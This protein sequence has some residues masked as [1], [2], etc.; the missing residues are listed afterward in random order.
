VGAARGMEYPW[1]P[2]RRYVARNS[3]TV[4]FRR[5]IHIRVD[6]PLISFTFDDFPRSALLAGGAILNRFGLAGTYYTA[7]GLLGGDSPS[8]A[9][10]TLD[11]LKLALD[12]GH[13]LGCHTFSHF[14]A[15]HTKSQAFEDS[16]IQNRRALSSLIP[17]AEFKSFSYPISSPRPTNKRAIAKL[18]ECCRGGGQKINA[19]TADL[20]QLSGYFLEKAGGCIP[21]IKSLIDTNKRERGWL[22]FATH[23]VA[24]D[25][26]PYGCTP[27]FFEDVVRYAADSGA[28]I[29]PVVRALEEIR[30]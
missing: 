21:P 5:P 4:L 22:I 6:R 2:I 10:F 20:N 12:K 24:N 19:G 25:P 8:G 14:D 29:L 27:E 30:A 18:F 28:R 9:L 13:E 11:D 1:E 15:W 3:A 16:V 26:S 23:D 17:G 7:M